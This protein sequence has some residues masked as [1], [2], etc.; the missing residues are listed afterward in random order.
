M[1]RFASMQSKPL[2]RAPLPKSYRNCVKRGRAVKCHVLLK[3]RQNLWRPLP[4]LTEVRTP[5][6]LRSAAK[7]Y[8][9]VIPVVNPTDY[10]QI[11]DTLR[12]GTMSDDASIPLGDLLRPGDPAAAD[13]LSL[14]RLSHSR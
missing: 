13:A 5:S 7:N 10:R 12:K 3:P 6:M 14:V 8:E 11:L 1:P 4:A 9:N 2:R